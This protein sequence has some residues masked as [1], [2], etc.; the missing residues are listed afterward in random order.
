MSDN[1]RFAGYPSA[2]IYNLAPEEKFEDEKKRK[3][4]RLPLKQLL[5]GDWVTLIDGEKEDVEKAVTNKDGEEEKWVKVHFRGKAPD[6]NGWVLESSLK[7]ERVL[8]IVFVDI[9]QGDGCLVVTPEDKH[10]LI[11]AGA[12]DNMFRFLRWRYGYFRQP[13]LFEAVVI[14]HSDSDHY[15]GFERIF[16]EK[17]VTVKTL[18]HN[19]IVERAGK[20]P[21]GEPRKI[22][23]ATYVDVI[24]D[25]Q[26]L[27]DFLSVPTNLKDKRDKIYPTMLKKALDSGCITNARMLCTDDK[28]LPDYEAGKKLSIEVLGPFPD[29]DNAGNKKVLRWFG[30]VGKTKN[31]HSVVLRLSYDKVKILLGGDLNIPSEHH[32]LEKHTKKSPLPKDD[33]EKRLLIQAARKV[34]Q[35]DIAK[36]CHHGSADFTDLFLQAVNPIATVISSGDEEPHAHPRADTLGTIGK[37]SRGSRSLIF[38]TELSRSAKEVIKE[39]FEFK[40]DLDE[41][42]KLI[43]EIER[44]IETA[45][46][47][48]N[49]AITDVEK[50]KAQKQLEKLEKELLRA[51]K[52]LEELRDKIGRSI[53]TYGAINVRTDGDKVVIAYKL[54]RIGEKDKE[55]D[56]YKLERDEAS[57][58][59]HFI[60]KYEEES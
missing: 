12:S 50:T 21:L 5:W 25:K 10:I 1:D 2:V 11:D 28:Y 19:G 14:S 52:N 18:Y 33:E 15:A 31:G 60:S 42:H 20:F 29:F 30:D 55:W 24:E 45:K 22:G 46:Q 38:S 44:Q 41:A 56:I 47:Q 37:Y 48:I 13:R 7:S 57:D 26:T 32:L 58:E 17:N 8:E 54:E 35:S 40:K 49:I 36:S 23:K 9:G 27:T 39:P 6:N 3:P 53:A 34:F 43:Y 16:D 59:L 51:Q 4:K